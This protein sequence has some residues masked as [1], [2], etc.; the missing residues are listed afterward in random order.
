MDLTG[1][2][3]KMAPDAVVICQ[4]FYWTDGGDSWTAGKNPV[5]GMQ[6]SLCIHCFDFFNN[7]G[8]GNGTV[9]NLQLT[10]GLFAPR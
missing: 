1:V 3:T 6:D 2:L 7:L 5:G 9:V 8:V 4:V 10:G